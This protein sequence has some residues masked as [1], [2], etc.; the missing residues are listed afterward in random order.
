VNEDEVAFTPSAGLPVTQLHLA[1]AL[2]RRRTRSASTFSSRAMWAWD[3]RVPLPA[4]RTIPPPATRTVPPPTTRTIPPPATRTNHIVRDSRPRIRLRVATRHQV[5]ATARLSPTVQTSCRDATS[6][7]TT[8][9][10]RPASVCVRVATRNH[11]SP[12]NPKLP[13]AHARPARQLRPAT[14]PETAR[15]PRAHA[16]RGPVWPARATVVSCVLSVIVS[17]WPSPYR[18]V[19]CPL[20]R[21]TP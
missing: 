10:R 2:H 12:R 16:L 11:D 14:Q 1:D 6:I 15:R 9:P 8:R 17:R 20:R 18:G 3:A 13:D 7:R 19:S 5:H 21:R 4:T